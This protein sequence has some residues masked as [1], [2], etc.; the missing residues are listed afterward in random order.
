MSPID[1]TSQFDGSVSNAIE[2]FK[3]N[4]YEYVKILSKRLNKYF[5]N[6]NPNKNEF[7]IYQRNIGVFIDVDKTLIK[8]HTGGNY[9][10][11]IHES[12]SFILNTAYH[13]QLIGILNNLKSNGVNLYIVSRG[14][15]SSIV[16]LLRDISMDHIFEQNKILSATIPLLHNKYKLREYQIHEPN[17]HVNKTDIIE[18]V[19]KVDNIDK[20]NVYFFDDTE[21]NIQYAIQHGY[22]NSYI[23]NNNSNQTSLL[24]LIKN[25]LYSNK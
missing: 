3:H 15:Y 19:C 8:G 11:N 4:P 12:I 6:P 5:H 1:K 22:R 20:Q 10:K 17:W 21:E 2:Y 7:Y 16:Q 25:R 9:N 18:A 23:V 24:F 13:K 14:N